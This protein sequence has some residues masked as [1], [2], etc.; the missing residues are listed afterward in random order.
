[1]ASPNSENY[2]VSN[3]QL[4][5]VSGSII[6]H[7]L[8]L[9]LQPIILSC[10]N[11]PGRS[12]LSS[13]TIITLAICAQINSP[14]TSSLDTM[15]PWTLMWPHWL[16]VLSHI[17]FTKQIGGP[18]AAFWRIDRSPHEAA[19][20]RGVFKRLRWAVALMINLRG[21]R[22]NYQV[23]N[24]PKQPEKMTKT[25]FLVAQGLSFLRVL[26]MCD[27]L[28][29]LAAHLFLTGPNGQPGDVNSK[30]LTLR[31]VSDWRWSLLKTLVFALGPYFFIS[32]QY[33][34]CS[35]ISVAVG[36]TIPEVRS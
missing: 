29:Q 28:L 25:V 26:L 27:L 30:L 36:L 23:K 19:L 6:P 35:F 31:Q 7:I 5:P 13:I 34:V 17:L 3:R 14:F 12:A 16:A 24:I 18:T 1:M 32:L 2:L 22:W 10:P 11:F 20:E 9:L 4:K 33:I 8:L 21:I 15:Q